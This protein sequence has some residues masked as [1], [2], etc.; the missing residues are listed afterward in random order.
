MED[1]MKKAERL[2]EEAARSLEFIGNR[3]GA[4]DYHRAVI[5]LEMAARDFAHV[6]DLVSA[7]EIL[8]L[9]EV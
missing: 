1:R 9:M 2:A 6:G 8:D 7:E 3:L 5:G 4:A